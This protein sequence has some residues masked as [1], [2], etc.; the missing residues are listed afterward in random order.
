MVDHLTRNLW[1]SGEASKNRSAWIS[2]KLVPKQVNDR[3]TKRD[4]PEGIDEKQFG[5]SEPIGRLTGLS[6]STQL[7]FA[8]LGQSLLIPDAG[9]R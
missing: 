3:R 4:P 7:L 2:G 9:P 5:W 8:C 6:I 1:K